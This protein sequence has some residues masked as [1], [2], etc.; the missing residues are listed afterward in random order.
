[1]ISSEIV[2][3]VTLTFRISNQ[4]SITLAARRTIADVATHTRGVLSRALRVV[5][6]K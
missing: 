2:H 1:M 6:R 5:G 4:A 3:A